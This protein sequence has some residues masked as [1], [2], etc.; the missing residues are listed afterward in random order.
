MERP[1]ERPEGGDARGAGEG[2]GEGSRTPDAAEGEDRGRQR[3]G[4]REQE[5]HGVTR[6][7]FVVGCGWGRSQRLRSALFLRLSR[8]LSV[9]SARARTRDAT[10]RAFGRAD[11]SR[12]TRASVTMP[13]R[14]RR[15]GVRAPRRESLRD[16][17]KNAGLVSGHGHQSGGRGRQLSDNIRKKCA[18][19]WADRARDASPRASPRPE[20]APRET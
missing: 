16:S 15:S 19:R 8:F 1:S 20:E 14:V 13:T 17:K 9:R 4:R 10:T 2:D 12:S 11:D 5:E 18:T 3:A 6:R 7:V